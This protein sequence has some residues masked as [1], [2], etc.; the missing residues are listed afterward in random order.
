MATLFVEDFPEFVRVHESKFL[1]P[2]CHHYSAHLE[3]THQPVHVFSTSLIMTPTFSE[4]CFGDEKLS[5]HG[6]A[7]RFGRIRLLHFGRNSERIGDSRF[8]QPKV[9]EL[10]CKSKDLSRTGI[11]VGRH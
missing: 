5:R 7:E 2:K 10:M 1:G 4:P 3:L 9:S 11:L 6:V 8:A